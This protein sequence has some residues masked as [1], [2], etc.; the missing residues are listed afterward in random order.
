RARGRSAAPR[1]GSAESLADPERKGPDFRSAEPTRAQTGAPRRVPQ[2]DVRRVDARRGILRDRDDV[3]VADGFA[4]NP[5]RSRQ[6]TPGG[7]M[8]G[9]E[10]GGAGEMDEDRILA[11]ERPAALPEELEWHGRAA[12]HGRRHCSRAAQL[13]RAEVSVERPGRSE[14]LLTQ[15]LERGFGAGVGLRER[16]IEAER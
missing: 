7:R 12:T 6:P 5:A 13:D 4:G 16:A 15:R 11:V 8:V 3:L 10:S 14:A 2:T 9:L 1:E